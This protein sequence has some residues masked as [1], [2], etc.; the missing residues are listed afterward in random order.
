MN[1]RY[2]YFLA[3][4]LFSVPFVYFFLKI[5]DGLFAIIVTMYAGAFVGQLNY[6]YQNGKDILDVDEAFLCQ[7]VRVKDELEL[8]LLE[9]GK[10]SNEVINTK[11]ISS[12]P[13]VLALQNILQD[14]TKLQKCGEALKQSLMQSRNAIQAVATLS[15]QY[16]NRNSGQ[17]S[18]GLLGHEQQLLAAI[19]DSFF[20]AELSRRII[21]RKITYGKPI[22]DKE[23]L[24]LYSHAL[25][26]AEHL[27]N[28]M[29]GN[30]LTLALKFT[31]F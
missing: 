11:L 29:R 5:P 8:Y 26:R 27:K 1:E 3:V 7:L 22:D 15:E 16:N 9:L 31:K 10:N 12:T 14:M 19:H 17:N 20:L 25:D 23:T 24:N 30:W 6:I 2:Q 21:Q 18:N 13:Q 28:N 4:M